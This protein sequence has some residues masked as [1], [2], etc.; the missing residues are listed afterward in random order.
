MENS[1]VPGEPVAHAGI[2]S[3]YLEA[4][5]GAGAS[6]GSKQNARDGIQAVLEGTLASFH[7]VYPC[8]TPDKER[9]FVMRVMP[10]APAG[11]GAV[12]VHTNITDQK[13]VENALRLSEER[14]NLALGAGLQGWFDLELAT[15]KVAVSPEYAR[16]LGHDP[17]TFHSSLEEWK[18]G[19]HPEDR[20]A[21]IQVFRECI[22]TGGPRTMEYRRKTAGGEW[23]WISSVG[24]IT[25]WD[26]Y[27]QALRMIGTH[28]DISARKKSEETYRTLFQTMHQGVV[29]QNRD[30]RI[31]SANPAAERILGR[32]LDQL[33]DRTSNDP[34]WEAIHEDGAPF[35]GASHPTM[36]AIT[37]GKPV[38]GVVMG[39][40]RPGSDQPVWIRI[41]ALPVFK[42]GTDQVDYAYSIFD[43]ITERFQWEIA[44]RES[45][46]RFR[47]LLEKIPLVSVQGYTVDGTTNY[48][49]DAS[50]HLYGYSAEEAIG[51]N[52][53]DLI[54]PPEMRAGVREAMRKM[55]TTGEPI[56]ASEL[57]LMRK[58]GEPVDVFSSHAIV[59]IP[60][61][62]P[63]LFCMDIDLSDR[64]RAEERIR[65]LAFFDE[66]T[67]LPNRRLLIDRAQQALAES[68]RNGSYGALLFID[69]DNFK[70]LNDTLGHAK[71]DQLLKLVAVRLVGCLREVDTAARLGGDE[72]IVMLKDLSGT[73]EE[74][75]YQAETAAEKIIA[76]LNEPYHL[77]ERVYRSTPSIGITLFLGNQTSVEDLMK[78]ADIAMYQ[79][80][81]AGRN[82]LRFFDP[83]MQYVVE[84]R[85]AIEEWMRKALT[86]H[87]LRLHY[88]I[89][90][91]HLG[92]ILG[93]EALLRWEH[94]ERGMIS[95]AEFIPLA[96]ETGLIIPIG[97]WVLDTA[98]AQLRAWQDDPR[99]RHL[100]IAVNV[101]A[102]QFTQND[103]L[104]Q[105][106]QALDKSGID[107]TRL[108]LELTESLV[109]ENIEHTIE[110]MKTLK[111]LGIQFSMDD[112]GT[113]H[114]SLS[115]LRQLPLDQLKIDQS[116]VR[117]ISMDP[118]DTVI[119]QTIIAMGNNL[120]LSVIA[121]GVETEMQKE[122]L[123]RHHCLHFQGYLFGK[124][125][126]ID[127]LE[128]MLG[129]KQG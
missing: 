42:E 94:P 119:V 60:G 92:Q 67:Q 116:F 96:E 28:S 19:I 48:W 35:P 105:V 78:R 95:P 115:S 55:F 41:S 15:G 6:P 10:L 98:C 33:L 106:K 87:Q 111:K 128:E 113:G 127:K 123:I 39:I 110:K 103:F 101:S 86:D 125:V 3:N 99:W 121:E 54:I 63:E 12:I 79:A 109:I 114:S 16:M 88:Q 34:G 23:K 40:R 122:F 83:E 57:R 14:L 1:P 45:E 72:F 8:S 117:D 32:P 58:G 61:L 118:D 46:Q 73:L 11:S 100:Q 51:R 85:S 31:I 25:E 47:N 18:E 36:L 21:V 50:E 7:T 76:R 69:L 56:P 65:N 29:Y 64:K 108:K 97:L 89:Q 129:R 81:K 20:D 22:A 70:I 30:G 27:G 26:A 102:R 37:T 90:V 124:P 38:D 75:A 59:K 44:L 24:E 53:C 120:G 49:N 52:L 4:C 17:M 84:A 66:L 43:D 77:D 93:A 80:K 126:P 62:E 104:A 13:L 112:F 2:G 68:N 91:D 71:G 74:A 82:T 9:W 5:R 107:P